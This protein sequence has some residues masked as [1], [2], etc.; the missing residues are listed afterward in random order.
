MQHTADMTSSPLDRGPAPP[1]AQLRYTPQKRWSASRFNARTLSDDGRMLLWNTLTG[2]VSEFLPAHRDGVLALLSEG[3]REPL[4]GL[5]AHMAKRGF[6]VPAGLD[7]L[8]R[9]RMLF[10]QQQWRSDVLQMILL[11][12]EDCNF[13]C[14]YCYEKFNHGT[15]LPEVRQGVRRLVEERAPRLRELSANWFGGEPL[16]GWEAIEELAPF[17]RATAD[18]YGLGFTSHMTTNGYLLDEDRAT[19]LL[20]WG[21]TKYQITIDGMPA[22]HDCKR[23]GRDGSGTWQVIM[24]NLRA[25]KQ[26]RAQFTITVRVNFDRDNYLK[27]GPFLEQLSEDFAGDPRYQLRFRQVGKWGGPNDDAL[28]TCGVA[29]HRYVLDELRGRAIGLGLNPEGGIHGISTP[30]SQV[31]YAGRPYHFIVGATGKLMKCTVVLDELPENVVGRITPE[32][33][34][35]VN[36]AH[37]LKWVAPLFETDQLCQSCYV[38]PGCQGAACPVTRITHGERTCCSVKSNLKRE[39]RFNLDAIRRAREAVLA[40]RAAEAAAAPA[41]APEPVAA[42]G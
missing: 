24:D 35:E 19:R 23:V 1:L 26:R 20:E 33:K 36:D 42:G 3:A 7:E 16:Y 10:G 22:E 6:L 25:M 38:L 5:A 11:A 18:R 17:F 30:G 40:Q 41:P 12:S 21:C 2:A 13:R 28:D 37:L 9:F 39:M 29:E 4:E 34:L 32:G 27:L 14:V 31:C 8:A 15:M